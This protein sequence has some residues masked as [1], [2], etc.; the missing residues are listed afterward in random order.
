MHYQHLI[1]SGLRYRCHQSER[2]CGRDNPWF[3]KCLW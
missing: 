1:I 3:C 2:K